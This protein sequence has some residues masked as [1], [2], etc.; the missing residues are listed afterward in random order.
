MPTPI[1]IRVSIDGL[2]AYAGGDDSWELGTP[3]VLDGLT[4]GWGRDSI[5][6][7]PDSGT[8]P[9]TLH[10]HLTGDPGQVTLFDRVRA[11][12]VVKIYSAADGA[13][14]LSWSG[15][16]T[17]A[18]VTQVNDNALAAGVTATDWVAPLSKRTIGADPWPEQSAGSRFNAII[19][20]TRKLGGLSTLAASMDDSLKDR[21]VAFRDVDKQ[22]PMDLLRNLA[23]TVGGIAWVTA[24]GTGPS[25]WIEDPTARQGLR[26]F[27]IAPGPEVSIGQVDLGLEGYNEWR[28]ADVVRD[29]LTWTQDPAQAVNTVEINWMRPAGRNEQRNPAYNEATTTQSD[30]STDPQPLTIDTEL[31]SSSDAT[32][33]ATR[34]MLNVHSADWLLAGLSIDTAALGRPLPGTSDAG[35]LAEVMAL[36]DIRRRIGRRLTIT[37]MPDWSP[38]GPVQS[39]Y[40]EGGTYTWTAGRWQ[41]ELTATSNAIGG[42]ATFRDF[43]GTG[44]TFADFR[45]TS[46]RVIDIA[47]VAGPGGFPI[48]FG[49][50]GFGQQPFGN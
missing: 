9:F 29:P 37:G 48:G 47:G 44:V 49:A 21:R 7:Q 13:E 15:K 38:V 45:P 23:Q 26:Q 12:A 19:A 16:I 35:R 5:V 3:T 25:V 32:L 14:V 17:S 2:D 43:A 46:L 6:D 39:F 11:G 34:W 20:A 4:F 41:L 30:G 28:A 50:G 27:V 1:T 36:L 40:I 18:N 31:V 10:Q 42:A 8:C 24:T 22:P 33:L